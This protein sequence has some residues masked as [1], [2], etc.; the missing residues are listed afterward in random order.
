MEDLIATFQAQANSKA[1]EGAWDG[2]EAV[3]RAAANE[4]FSTLTKARLGGLPSLSTF[5]PRPF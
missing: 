1:T 3:S 5:W 4:Y 2:A